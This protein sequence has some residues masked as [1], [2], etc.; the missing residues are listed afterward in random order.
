MKIDPSGS[1]LDAPI[2]TEENLP[3]VD[4][5]IKKRL[6]VVKQ[7]INDLDKDFSDRS[8]AER[9]ANI[10]GVP[11]KE[12][13]HRTMLNAVDKR[14]EQE[15]ANDLVAQFMQEVSLDEAAKEAYEDPI[16]SIERRLAAL[17]GSPIDSPAEQT[18]Q[19]SSPEEPDE[20]IL[21][22][23]IA[24]KVSPYIL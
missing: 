14:T 21:A 16:K 18:G 12:Y 8:I 9:L 6:E 7:P 17:K 10:K 2:P 22:K 5:E 13:D 3:D 20:D 15:K 4:D 11:H 1:V 23:K 24:E 19:T